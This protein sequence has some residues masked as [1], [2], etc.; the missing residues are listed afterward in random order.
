[1][2]FLCLIN[3]GTGLPCTLKTKTLKYLEN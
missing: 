3:Y 1:M 2:F